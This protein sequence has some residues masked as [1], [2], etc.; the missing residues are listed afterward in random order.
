MGLGAG[1]LIFT[2]RLEPRELAELTTEEREEREEDKSVEGPGVLVVD[3]SDG[4]DREDEEDEDKSDEP[5][6]EMGGD[7]DVMEGRVGMDVEVALL[8][9]TS[10]LPAVTV[11]TGVPLPNPVESLRMITTTVPAGIVTRSQVYDLPVTLVKAARTGPE[12][13]SLR[14]A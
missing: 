9:Q 6:E 12:I 14:K 2:V 11:I 1:V 13:P 5:K 7:S 3:K 8:T 10:E 4:E